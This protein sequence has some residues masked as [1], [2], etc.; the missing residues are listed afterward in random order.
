MD[1]P[2]PGPAPAVMIVQHVD[3]NEYQTFKMAGAMRDWQVKCVCGGTKDTC[4][5]GW[6]RELENR[7]HRVIAPLMVGGH[8]RLSET[9]HKLVATW[10]I[11][12][13]MVSNH[14][15]V[16]HLQRKQ[17]REKREPPKGWG[18]WIANYHRENWGAEWLCRR[19]SVVPDHILAKRTSPDSEPTS[20]ATT[21]IFQKLFIHVVY[22]RLRSLVEW[23]RFPSP[24]GG[25][26]SGH[27]VRIWPPNRFGYS[28]VWPRKPL[29]DLD[30]MTISDA[31][32]RA[33]MTLARK[34]I[35]GKAPSP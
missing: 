15:L 23:W 30:A 18:V 20:H 35:L 10:A 22:C 6:M 13:V 8:T 33:T 34:N 16:H 11:L 25:T 3:R 27:L 26:L 19:F 7:V 2:R 1:P 12:K 5:N 14:H 21:L 32:L 29:T 4:N 17:M 9:D 28:T 31:L 24:Q